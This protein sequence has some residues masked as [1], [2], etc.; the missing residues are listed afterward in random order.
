M[1]NNGT[2]ALI[3]ELKTQNE[4]FEFYPTTDE[5]II[6]LVKNI[7]KLDDNSNHY[8]FSFRSILDIGAGNGKVL[9]AVEKVFDGVKLYAIEKAEILKTL[10]KK[11]FYLVGTDFKEQSLL[12]KTMSV[13]FCNPPY[14]EYQDWAVK[15]IRESCSSYVYLVI[16]QRWVTS[17]DIADAITYRETEAEVIGSFSFINSE[18]RKARAVV[19]LIRIKLPTQTDDA[20]DK[21]F[22]EEFKDLK[23]RFKAN[24]E[25]KADEIKGNKFSGLVVGE[26][27]VR[28]LVEMYNADIENIKSNYMKVKELDVKLLDEFDISVE[29]ILDLLKVKLKGLKNLYWKELLSRMDKI[30]SRLISKKR[31][32]LFDK[33]N[34]SGYVDFT[35]SNIYAVVLWIL[36]NSSNY[37]DEQVLIVYEDL[38]S[39][40]NCKNYK[41]N[42][43]VFE[44]DDWRYNQEK[45]THVYLD[46]RIILQSWGVLDY[47]YRDGNFA[48]LSESAC[49]RVKD[50]LTVA[51]NLGF[52]T[53]S[54]DRRLFNWVVDPCWV[55]GKPQ[56]F[57]YVRNGE[58]GILFE[59]KAHKNGNMHIRL[60]QKFAL[61]LNVEYGRLKGW[62]HS[63]EN[64]AEELKDV[65]AAQYFK[66]NYSLLSSPFIQIGEYYE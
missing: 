23:E 35:E 5:I 3:E 53:D 30:T 39:K 64:A 37:I 15:I 11:G 59:V 61:A 2:N 17:S 40:A 31:N 16:P 1:G 8:D 36:E 33:L 43:R 6:A 54:T 20:F 21:F 10:I 28:A 44:N 4:D 57:Y 26:N 56:S 58:R 29:K 34:D 48:R 42:H 49:E 9:S 38:M 27:Y 25:G 63:K 7:K 45:P 60:N 65:K 47:G 55:A 52:I 18:D 14:S 32:V 66:T 22:N 19:N 24:R 51:N 50:L 41:S 12:D 46:F 62:I 13:T